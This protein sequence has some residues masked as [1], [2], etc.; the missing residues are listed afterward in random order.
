MEQ[1]AQLKA[2]R[3]AARARLQVL[4]DWKLMTSLDALIPELEVAF[5]VAPEVASEDDEEGGEDVAD[6]DAQHDIEEAEPSPPEP[7]EA[8]SKS[9]SSFSK[10]AQ[11]AAET[12]EPESADQDVL[13]DLE[14]VDLEAEIA[15][16]VE[17]NMAK[18][19]ESVDPEE[20]AVNRALDEL[21]ADL[22]DVDEPEERGSLL[23]FRQ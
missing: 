3:D 6:G 23:K 7:I 14:V 22:S 18:L 12:A 13:V 9:R 20:D 1:I 21:R 16:E 2:M 4:P 10:P 15:S 5:G 11:A 8:T 17:A 19:A